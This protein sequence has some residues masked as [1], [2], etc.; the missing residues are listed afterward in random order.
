MW[1]SRRRNR[2]VGVSDSVHDRRSLL[3]SV[4]FGT[5]PDGHDIPSRESVSVWR[6]RTIARSDAPANRLPGRVGLARFAARRPVGADPPVGTEAWGETRVLLPEELRGRRWHRVIGTGEV[7][8]PNAGSLMA[9]RV[10][11]EAPVELLLG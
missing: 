4:T 3:P 7:L 8:E 10:L 5:E 6:D 1:P 11:R 9:C 2:S